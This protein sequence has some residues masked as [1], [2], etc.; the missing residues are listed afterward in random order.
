MLQSNIE[1]NITF[2]TNFLVIA[3]KGKLILEDMNYR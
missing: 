1:S 2:C 3:G